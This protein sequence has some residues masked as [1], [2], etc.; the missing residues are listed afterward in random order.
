MS[1]HGITCAVPRCPYYQDAAGHM[2]ECRRRSPIAHRTHYD[3]NEYCSV[4]PPVSGSDDFCGNHPALAAL[5]RRGGVVEET[6]G[7]D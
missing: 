4:W 5:V 2:G 3:R 6:N 1:S 7:D